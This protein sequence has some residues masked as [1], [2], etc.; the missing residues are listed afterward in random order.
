[1]RRF[2]LVLAA[3]TLS[4]MDVRMSSAEFRDELLRI[5]AR[6]DG[7]HFGRS[8]DISGTTVIIGTG[9]WD[10]S[11]DPDDPSDDARSNWCPTMDP[12]PV[13]LDDLTGSEEVFVYDYTM[14][15]EPIHIL[16]SNSPDE[17]DWFGNS[18]AVDGDLAVV[19][20]PL[21]DAH[22]FDSGAAYLFD[23]NT[24]NQL[25]KLVPDDPQPFDRFGTSVAIDGNF[26]VVAST[27]TR[28]VHVY[29][30]TTGAMVNK[31]TGDSRRFGDSV[32][33]EGNTVVVG[34][35]FVGNGKGGIGIAFDAVTSD[36]LWKFESNSRA[37]AFGI[38]VD[39]SG[40]RTIF[41]APFTS[42][43]DGQGSAHVLNTSTGEHQYEIKPVL[44]SSFFW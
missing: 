40:D 4:H 30:T 38:S 16:Q 32:A 17:G 43:D 41:G 3:T 14:G 5:T 1:M 10:P 37:D 28:T 12:V 24:G 27:C 20:A 29:D 21:E 39:V 13:P 8:V 44:G 6:E 35:V 11:D 2:F 31:L 42:H 33:I 9:A 25:F 34:G 22:G 15:S 19:G 26:A 18:V 23:L 36:V 7:I